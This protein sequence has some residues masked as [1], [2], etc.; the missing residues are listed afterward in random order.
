MDLSQREGN[1]PPPSGSSEI[2]GVEFSGHVH[3]LGSEA[4]TYG[5]N[6]GDEVLG[7]AGGVCRISLF[8]KR[9]SDIFI[10]RE[11]M[12]NTLLYRQSC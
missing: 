6:I 8:R 11:P 3:E 4:G 12:R 9:P 5:F 10:C 1:Y 7:L 2:L